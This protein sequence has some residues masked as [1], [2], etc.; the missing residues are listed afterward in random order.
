MEKDRNQISNNVQERPYLWVSSTR[1]ILGYN[2]RKTIAK[3]GELISGLDYNT[4][5][6]F[7][8]NLSPLVKKKLKISTSFY[9]FHS[10]NQNMQAFF[11][12]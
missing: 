10:P 8:I 12:V 3:G 1:A 7:I 4:S 9:L 5:H 11:I 2:P 6:P